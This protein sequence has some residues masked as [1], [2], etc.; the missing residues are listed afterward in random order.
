M[1]EYKG[2]ER[3]IEVVRQSERDTSKTCSACGTKDGNQRVE[4]GLYVCD[5]CG[6][7]ANADVNGAENI[8]R[9]VP[10]SPK[11]DRSTGWMAQ[12]AVH[13]FDRSEGVSPRENRPW[14]ANPNIPTRTGNSGVDGA[15][16]VCVRDL[17][18]LSVHAEEDV[19]PSPTGEH[20]LPWNFR[21]LFSRD[22]AYTHAQISAA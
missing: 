9:K 4:R 20:Q 5:D 19:I 2:E 1:L 6:T 7:V 16:A 13:L 14:T 12:L 18:S 11:R 10:P 21:S 8:R 22:I 17:R 15:C 3:G